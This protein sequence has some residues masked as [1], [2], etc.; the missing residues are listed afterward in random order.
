[1]SRSF[2]L[3]AALV[4]ALVAMPTAPAR[5]SGPSDRCQSFAEGCA[6]TCR[7]GDMVVVSG[8]QGAATGGCGGAEAQCDGWPDCLA[9][10]GVARYD[11]VGWCEISSGE[12]ADCFALAAPVGFSC[13]TSVA[14]AACTYACSP[15]GEVAVSAVSEGPGYPRVL[16]LCGDVATGCQAF[17]A[18]EASTTSSVAGI[19]VCL[20][21][22]ERTTIVCEER[23]APSEL[24]SRCVVQWGVCHFACDEGAVLAAAGF[25]EWNVPSAVA[26]CGGVAAACEGSLD[27][28][29]VGQELTGASLGICVGAGWVETDGADCFALP[30]SSD[31][32]C[33]TEA[34]YAAC[35]FACTA[36]AALAVGATSMEPYAFPRVV[37]ACGDGSAVCQARLA[38][39]GAGLAS[40]AGLG[41]CLSRTVATRTACA[42]A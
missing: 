13:T 3:L 17:G 34:D 18:C 41:V 30:A 27:C 24:P 35:V 32:A 21:R 28:L 40:R 10:A 38:C 16:S 12:Y 31:A 20:S 22:T 14:Y 4:L 26:A 6:F 25:G 15:A 29:A 7:A 42:A 23:A 2:T 19:G 36:G 8:I 5:E 11:D 9:V 33:T 37:S 1:M 39:A